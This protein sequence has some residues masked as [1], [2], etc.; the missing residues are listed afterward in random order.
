[1][2]DDT[3]LM[4]IGLG[5]DLCIAEYHMNNFVD[6]FFLDNPVWF[7]LGFWGCPV[8]GSWPSTQCQT[9]ASSCDMGHKLDQSRVGHKKKWELFRERSQIIKRF[10][11]TPE[12]Y[13][14]KEINKNRCMDVWER[15]CH[16]ETYGIPRGQGLAMAGMGYLR[17]K[18]LCILCSYIC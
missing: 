13:W 16:N 11:G 2:L 5:T 12:I 15:K 4:I 18:N 14:G 6:F 3:L 10:I 9:W 8:S 1:M 7:H 17:G